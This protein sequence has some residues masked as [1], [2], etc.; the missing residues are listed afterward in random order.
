MG[1]AGTM[2]RI[3]HC[4]IKYINGDH[5]ADRPVRMANFRQCGDDQ[6]PTHANG[7]RNLKI[8]RHI[9]LVLNHQKTPSQY[10]VATHKH[11]CGPCFCVF[12]LFCRAGRPLS[13]PPETVAISRRTRR[14]PY[15]HNQD[16]PHICAAL[17]PASEKWGS[18]VQRSPSG[19]S[20]NP[21]SRNCR[22]HC[23]RR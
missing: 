4:Q 11:L 12:E 9:C 7:C 23:R 21:N 14:D 3:L 13:R 8:G 2:L 6:E 15:G 18:L 19:S 22:G 5:P 17:G 1:I 16:L 20:R 10:R